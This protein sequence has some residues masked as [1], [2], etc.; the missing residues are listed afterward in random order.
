MDQ[1]SASGWPAPAK[2]NWFLHVVGKRSDGYH[3]LQTVFQFLDYG[4]SMTFAVNDTGQITRSYDFGF[5]E[6]V[7]ICL[8]AARL[9]Q[10]RADAKPGVEIGLEKCLPMGGGLGGGSSNA[11]TTLLAL[12]HLWGTGLS[13]EQ[14]ARLGLQLGADVPVFI[15]GQAAWAEGVGEILTPIELAEKWLL[16]VTPQRPVS[17]ADIFAHKHLTARPQMKKIR[18]LEQGETTLFGEN[19]LQDLVCAD[20][21]EVK[22]VLE[23]LSEFGPARMSGSGG[24]VFLPLLSRQ[25]GLELLQQKPV[26]TSAFVARGLNQHPLFDP[27]NWPQE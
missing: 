14:L 11:A 3:L 16:V 24:S 2:I 17:T 26:N 18:A 6:D 4:D 21:P 19:Q 5:T 15:M 9:L 7:D 13:R 12:N 1:L 27:L 22:A 25:Q 20:Y 8:R 10:G 23:W